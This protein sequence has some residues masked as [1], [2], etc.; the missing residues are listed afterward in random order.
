LMSQV[1]TLEA[2]RPESLISSTLPIYIKAL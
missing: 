1:L 2:S